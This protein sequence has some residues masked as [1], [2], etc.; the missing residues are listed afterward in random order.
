MSLSNDF[1]PASAIKLASQEI[2]ELLAFLSENMPDIGDESP[3]AE[4]KLSAAGHVFREIR[5]L[6]GEGIKASIIGMDASARD[7]I[8]ASMHNPIENFAKVKE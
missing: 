3:E 1:P 5:R 6:S 7:A 8:T 2:A 4:R